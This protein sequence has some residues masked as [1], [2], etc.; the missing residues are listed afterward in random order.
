MVDAQNGVLAN[1]T[2]PD[3]DPLEVFLFSGPNNG[4]VFLN[5]DGSFEAIAQ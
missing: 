2:D 3:G 4:S 5:P 1:D